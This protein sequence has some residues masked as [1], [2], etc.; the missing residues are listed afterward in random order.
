VEHELCHADRTGGRALSPP[1]REPGG[2]LPKRLPAQRNNESHSDQFSTGNEF[3][4]GNLGVRGE[5][6]F[7]PWF[8]GFSAQ[9]GLGDMHESVDTSGF[10]HIAVA[11]TGF[12]STT[13]GG[14][15]TQRSNIGKQT[16]DTFACVPE[17]TLQAGYDLTCNIRAFVGYNFLYLSD[18]VRPGDQIDRNVNFNQSGITVATGAVALPVGPLAPQPQFNHTDFWAQGVNI[19]LIVKF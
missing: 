4:G 10:T 15:F 14:I 16:A 6:R 9:V 3:W 19:G 12:T 5:L 7:C 17:V 1:E 18:V 11:T 13:A 8:V 2:E